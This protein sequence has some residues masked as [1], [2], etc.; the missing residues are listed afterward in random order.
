MLTKDGTSAGKV[1]EFSYL[2]IVATFLLAEF[3]FIFFGNYVIYHGIVSRA[4]TNVLQYITSRQMYF[5]KS[6]QKETDRK[7]KTFDDT[8]IFNKR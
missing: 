1:N 7:E 6:T 2:V 5:T 3:C 4:G 8:I